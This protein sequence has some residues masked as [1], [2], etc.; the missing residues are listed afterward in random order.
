MSQFLPNQNTKTTQKEK[1]IENKQNE[2]GQL[3]TQK[4]HTKTKQNTTFLCI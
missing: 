3:P 2:K 1:P 4:K